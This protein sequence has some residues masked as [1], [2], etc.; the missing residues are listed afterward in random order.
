MHELSIAQA[1][2]DLAEVNRPPG[3]VLRSVHVCAGP[4][5]AIDA[6]A[7]TFAWSSLLSSRGLPPIALD[8]HVLPWRMRCDSCGMEWTDIDPEF[9]C[10]C[11]SER[12]HPAGSDELVLDSIDVDEE[13]HHESPSGPKHPEVE[14]RDRGRQP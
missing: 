4:L 5:R 3:T 6:D 9:T 2:L 12:V 13:I 10:V 14:R 7:L 8:L 1:M 11:G